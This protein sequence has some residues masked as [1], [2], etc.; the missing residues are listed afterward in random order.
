MLNEGSS[1]VHPFCQPRREVSNKPSKTKKNRKKV[2]KIKPKYL[3]YSCIKRGGVL[4]FNGSFKVLVSWLTQM[5]DIQTYRI[6]NVPFVCKIYNLSI[7]WLWEIFNWDLLK[8]EK[9]FEKEKLTKKEEEEK[10]KEENI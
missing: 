2:T 8:G 1:L 9:R 3:F 4:K 6:C 10:E 5:G 7:I